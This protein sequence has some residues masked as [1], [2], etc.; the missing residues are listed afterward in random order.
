MNPLPRSTATRLK[1]KS[2]ICVLVFVVAVLVVVSMTLTRK[3]LARRG[4][5]VAPVA[6]A[7]H[8]HQA[9]K[10]YGKLPLSFERNDGQAPEAVRFMSRGVGYSLF[11]T[12]NQAVLTLRGHSAAKTGDA[13]QTTEGYK[14]IR[15]KL[16]GANANPETVGLE[17]LPGKLNY[18]I[19]NEPAKWAKDVSLYAK[20]QYRSVYDGIDLLYYGNQR[21]LEYD[22][23]VAPGRDPRAIKLEFEGADRIKVEENDGSLVLAIEQR[24]VR[25]KRPVIYQLSDEGNRE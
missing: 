21:Q 16:L 12:P 24:E 2:A 7:H 22:F 19:G 4:D 23:Q 11:L 8:E 5:D 3:S 13:A 17:E 18:F 25:F 15:M 9:A 1:T 10:A 20:V 6:Q 14:V